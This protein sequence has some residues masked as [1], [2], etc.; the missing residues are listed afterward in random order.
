MI[1]EDAWQPCSAGMPGRAQATTL[2]DTW[3]AAPLGA[4]LLDN[5]S[6]PAVGLLRHFSQGRVV[7][8]AQQ[9]QRIDGGH[10]AAG[11]LLVHYYVAGEEEPHGGVRLQSPVGQRWIAGP[12]D[13]VS[14]EVLVQLLLDRRLYVDLRQDA[15]ALLLECRSGRLHRLFIVHVHP[16]AEADVTAH[17]YPSS[18]GLDLGLPG[19]PDHLRAIV[20][21]SPAVEPAV[22]H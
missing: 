8:H 17:P 19:H 7:E 1:P 21:E 3:K 13:D 12:Q 20:R 9:G 4:Q 5:P 16:G 6:Q 14:T 15:E 10:D 18:T 11:A 22:A 2:G